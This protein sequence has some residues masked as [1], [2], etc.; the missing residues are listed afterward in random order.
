MEYYLAIK[1][2]EITPFLVTWIH[3]EITILNEVSQT[4]I[5]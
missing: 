2:N 1:N 3:P 5:I 4:N